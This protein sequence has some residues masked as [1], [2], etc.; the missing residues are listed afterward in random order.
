MRASFRPKGEIIE[1]RAYP[2]QRERLLE[3]A[4]SHIQH[5]QKAL[6][7][8]GRTDTALGAFYRRLS[9]RIGKIKANESATSPCRCRHHRH[10]W[11]TAWR[12]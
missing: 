12:R 10:D 4:A 1:L 3:H 11:A 2:R 6:S 7:E 9:A 5:M 8:I